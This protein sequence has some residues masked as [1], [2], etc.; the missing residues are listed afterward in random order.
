MKFISGCFVTLS[1][2]AL[3]AVA[4]APRRLSSEE[5]AIRDLASS[6]CARHVGE[7]QRRRIE[8]RAKEL[9]KRDGTSTVTITTESPYY[10]EI[11]NETCIL[12]P[13]VTTGPYIWPKS[14][15]LRQDMTEDQAG[16]PLIV[17]IGVI[18]INTCEPM[19][20]VLVDVWHCN[21]T[22]S[23]S[24]FTKRDPNTPF[25]ELLEQLNITLVPGVELDLHTDDTTFL[26]GMWPTNEEGVMEMK[27]IVPGYYVERAIHVHVQVHQD[28]VLQSNGTVLTD[29]TS[30]TGQF[31]LGEELSQY[32][33]SLEP[34][35]SHTEIERTTND[36]DGIYQE[37]ARNGWF[38]ELAV[39]PM[40]GEDYANGVIGYITVG[41]DA[42]RGV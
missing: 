8:K 3:L 24:S 11:Q 41:V 28:W 34:Y 7:M 10:P 27:T 31:F 35:S 1:V 36:V 15:T 38:P 39:V 16:I 19:Q 4:H 40:D 5:I 12:T 22:G 6:K 9:T 14:Q 37:E 29:T 33:M 18:D 42:T 26:R 13:E 20:N 2:Y 25:E 30:S 17:D 23:Y 32:L 21:A